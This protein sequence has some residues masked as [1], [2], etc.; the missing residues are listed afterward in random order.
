S[1][2]FGQ[3]GQTMTILNPLARRA[4]SRRRLLVAT[5]AGVTAITL[6]GALTRS[7]FAQEGPVRWVSPRGT[8]EVLDDYPYWIAKK[9]GY[10]GDLPTEIEAGPMDATAT[11]KLVDQGQ[12]DM[13]YPSPGVFSLGLAQ[14]IPLVSVFQMGAT[15]VFDF[16]FRK[17]EA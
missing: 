10:F 3:G 16:A 15:D 5:G 11:I 14:G 12:A 17:G 2:D 6:G 13:G 8:L 4:V 9:F 1:G 7:A